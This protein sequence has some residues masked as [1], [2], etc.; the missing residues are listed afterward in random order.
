MSIDEIVEKVISEIL[1]QVEQDKTKPQS[2][3]ILSPAVRDKKGEF[4]DLFDNLQSKGYQKVI[5]DGK[6]KNLSDDINLIK[7]NK[8]KIDV[9]ID[10][11]IATNKDLKQTNYFNS[12][13]SRL[14][15]AVEQSL[16]LSDGLVIIKTDYKEHLYSEK[17]SCPICNLSLPEIEPR[18]FSFNSPLGACEN[19]RGIGTIFAVDR[20]LILNK[21]LS[22]LEG[23]ILPFNKLFFHETWYVRLIKQVCEE[24]GIDMNK[25]ISGLTEKQINTILKGTNKT[26]RV[27][28]LN[29]FGHAT[30][31]TEKFPGIIAELERRY[32]ETQGDYSAMEI[33]K[34]MR[35][36]TCQKCLG[37]RL[38]PEI[39][40]ITIEDNNIAQISDRPIDNLTSYFKEK[41]ESF[42]SIYEKQV[43]KSII[44]EI[45]TRLNFLNSVGLSYLTISRRAGTLSGGE[46]QRIRLASQIG[47]GLTGVLYVLDEPSIGLH[48]RDVA[49][50]IVTLKNLRDLGNSLIVVEHD[51]ETM[52]ASDYL[53]E[54]GEKAGKDGGKIIFNGQLS[55]IK[56]SKISLTGKY[57]N[58]KR[59]MQITGGKTSP[60]QTNHGELILTGITH[61]NLKNINI[62]IPL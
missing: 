47:S 49:S 1:K 31:I 14:R 44:K 16:K 12:F 30:A 40:S 55:E 15:M 54:L 38:K 10:R 35:E 23:G 46:L 43:A 62:K 57:L 34:Y 8:H 17:F 48:P 52:E 50:L 2:F 18:M 27:E 56:K 26:Y 5:I 59:L 45:L 28:G 11:L 36:E 61:N 20:N 4:K 9:S 33:Q 25:Q 37:L 19:C 41:L 60:L 13:K 39:L 21:N 7:T 32:V 53:V 42:L 3:Y 58:G 24:E 29:R 51:R 22:I 6:E